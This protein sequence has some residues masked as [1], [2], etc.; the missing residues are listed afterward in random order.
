MSTIIP[1]KNPNLPF[2]LRY[3]HDGRQRE[4]SFRTKREAKDF[5]AKFEHDSR[6]NIFVDPRESAVKFRDASAQ[7]VSRLTGAESSK[8][9]YRNALGHLNDEI[10]NR[11]LRHVA[12]DRFGLEELLKTTLPGKGLG[13]SMIRTCYI[14][15][16]AVVNDS[17]KAGKLHTS[18]I[19]NITLPRLIARAEIVWP[20]YKQLK[21]IADGMPDNWGLAVWLMRGC[22][23]RIGEVLAV[24]W[25]NF[26]DGVLRVKEQLDPRGQYIPLKHRKADEYRDVPV[27]TYVLAAMDLGT[28]VASTEASGRYGYVFST[29][30]AGRQRFS[31]AFRKLSTEAGLPAEFTAHTLRH[32]FASVSLSNGV[33]ITDVSAWLGHRD[34]NMTYAI[35]GHLV[36]SSWGKA[37]HVLDDEF[38]SW[39]ETS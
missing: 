14:V 12:A 21:H 8:R 37:R 19:N 22:G 38:A 6:E 32:I 17:I 26:N 7:W 34:I 3:Y 5:Q 10:G 30:G 33:P 20:E 25:E 9:V 11:S 29:L 39:K 24:R 31:R 1:G 23:L 35:Y 18:R 2:T 28:S 13:A 27:P 16:R 15:V 36:P 4:K